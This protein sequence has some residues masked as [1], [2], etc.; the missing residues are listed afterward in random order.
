MINILNLSHLNVVVDRYVH[1]RV[2]HILFKFMLVKY[3]FVYNAFKLLYV[4]IN[5]K[6]EDGTY[7]LYENFFFNS[8]E[9]VI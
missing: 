7:F 8:D 6:N 2:K 9:N 3:E 1:G 4:K 5:D